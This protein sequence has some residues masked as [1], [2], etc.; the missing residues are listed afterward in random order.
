MHLVE[1]NRNGDETSETEGVEDLE[2]HNAISSDDDHPHLLVGG[3]R[4][5]RF[6]QH[7][8]HE[9]VVTPQDTLRRCDRGIVEQ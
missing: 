6:V 2:L 4:I 5:D 1:R 9:R 3:C 7:Q 8:V